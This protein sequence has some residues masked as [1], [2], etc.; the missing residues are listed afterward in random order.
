MGPVLL[1]P[2]TLLFNSPNKELMPREGGM[3]IN[4]DN[5]EDHNDTL[6][7]QQNKVVKKKYTVRES[8]LIPMV[9][10]VVIK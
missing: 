9:C 4:F 8:S 5:D 3:P 10:T 2:V 6:K 1:S 7:A